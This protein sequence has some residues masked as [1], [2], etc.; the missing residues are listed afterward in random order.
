MDPVW[1]VRNVARAWRRSVAAKDFARHLTWAYGQGLGLGGR[2]FNIAFRYPTPVGDIRLRLRSN[3][4]ADAFIHGEVFEHQ[5]YRLPLKAVPTTILDLG[6]NIGLTALYFARQF[7]CAAIACV[8][9]I[10]GNLL[11]LEQN[12][13]M[14]AVDAKVFG[15]AIDS[16]DG[17]VVMEL[18]AND[19]GHRVAGSSEAKENL[20]D[21]PAISIPTLLENLGWDRIGLMKVDIEGHEKILFAG[22]C[23]WLDR[24]DAICIEWHGERLEAK[25]EL[26]ALAHQFGFTEPKL[27]SDIWFMDRAT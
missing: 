5:Y 20:L 19:Y 11:L 27:L 4:G 3:R 17:R 24:V 26:T 13:R 22:D 23:N 25:Q 15:A 6:A 10:P 18:N 14:N 12:L 1:L 2:E 21:V 7:P 9:P 16:E 8:E